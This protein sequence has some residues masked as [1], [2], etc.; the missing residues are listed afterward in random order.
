M[1]VQEILNQRPLDRDTCLAPESEIGYES[2]KKALEK[3]KWL[4]KLYPT[5]DKLVG[6]DRPAVD[7]TLDLVKKN[8]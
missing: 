3:A 1:K 8:R 4:Q 5:V 6:S 7:T 2:A